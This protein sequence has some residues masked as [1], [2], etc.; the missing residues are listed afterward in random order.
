MTELGER[1]DVAR[2]HPH[3]AALGRAPKPILK[4]GRRNFAMIV[5]GVSAR[6]GEE[7]SSA[8]PRHG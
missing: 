2:D 7:L 5:M 1:Y 6:P 3:L 8:T 4:E